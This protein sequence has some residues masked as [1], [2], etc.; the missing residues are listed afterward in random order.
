MLW[1]SVA[2]I[3]H[4]RRGYH[5]F[6]HHLIEMCLVSIVLYCE[7]SLLMIFSFVILSKSLK[8]IMGSAEQIKDVLFLIKAL[9]LTLTIS[10]MIQA[11]YSAIT[12]LVFVEKFNMLEHIEVE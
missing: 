8:T 2:L 9:F 4:T 10:Y 12:G 7:V 11:V 5:D 6:N 3:S 1:Q